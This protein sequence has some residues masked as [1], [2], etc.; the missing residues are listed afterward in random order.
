MIE[1][2]NIHIIVL[3]RTILNFY[4]FYTVQEKKLSLLMI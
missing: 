1:F 3:E 2:K 4:V